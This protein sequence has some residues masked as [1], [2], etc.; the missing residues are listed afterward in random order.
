MNHKLHTEYWQ[1]CEAI[2]ETRDTFLTSRRREDRER[3]AALW[4]RIAETNEEHYVNFAHKLNRDES[5][6]QYFL[7]CAKKVYTGAERELLDEMTAAAVVREEGY[8][9]GRRDGI[10]EVF[11]RDRKNIEE[12]QKFTETPQGKKKREKAELI[13]RICECYR[14]GK[15]SSWEN[16]ARA[17]AKQLGMQI[18]ARSRGEQARQAYCEGIAARKAKERGES[19][20]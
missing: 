17:A 14:T 8:E 19:K 3:F 16:A 15:Y 1:A 9:R 7:D 10:M 18:N 13:E 11:D 12:G 2:K 20:P 4:K 6:R 5:R